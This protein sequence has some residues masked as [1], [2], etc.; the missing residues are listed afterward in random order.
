MSK[1]LWFISVKFRG[2]LPCLAGLSRT[3][4]WAGPI[5]SD[6][7]QWVC[8]L[9]EVTERIIHLKCSCPCVAMSCFYSS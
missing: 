4:A 6:T 3:S 9:G 5:F 2:A 8:C 1:R 7:F